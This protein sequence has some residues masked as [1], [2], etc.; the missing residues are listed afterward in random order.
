MAHALEV[1]STHCSLVGCT[2]HMAEGA[3]V[4][5]RDYGEL[6]WPPNVENLGEYGCRLRQPF[7]VEQASVGPPHSPPQDFGQRDHPE[8][9]FAG[10]HIP[11]ERD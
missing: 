2:S 9:H 4:A 10:Q 11:S 1:D 3:A 7:P 6:E 5:V 8:F